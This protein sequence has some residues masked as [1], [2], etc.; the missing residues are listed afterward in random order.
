MLQTAQTQAITIS[1]EDVVHQLKLS[2]QMPSLVEGIVTR[3]IINSAAAEAGIEVETEEL[4]KAADQFRV[5]N[6]ILSAD[7]TQVW[8]QKHRLSLDD[9][10][11]L[12]YTNVISGKLAQ[13]LFANEVEPYFY[14]H[15]L[16]YAGAVM[17]E[18]VLDD[19]DLAREFFY[20]ITE[21]EM[22][23]CEVAH[24]YIQ[25]TELRRCGGYRGRVYRSQM[26]P[27]VSAAVFAAIPPQVLK[28]IVTSK[29][30]HLVFVEEIIQP[31]LDEQRR[32]RILSDLFADWLKRQ[33]EQ[34]EVVS[35]LESNGTGML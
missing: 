24:Q 14:E 4:Q 6:Q 10:E 25:E 11:E 21:G 34:V 8:L 33:F 31:E 32:Y 7:A 28:P 1:Q 13:H 30:V 17:Y 29:G 19:E 2:L 16:D 35:S 18:V 23:F 9:F 27:E 26:K 5:N 22:S 12:V 20:A 3:K 15:Q